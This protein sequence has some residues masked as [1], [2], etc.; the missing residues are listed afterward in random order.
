MSAWQ[1]PKF[2]ISPSF[3]IQ[4]KL[5]GVQKLASTAPQQELANKRLRF[6]I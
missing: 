5:L 3:E 1:N 2:Y 4:E 6:K